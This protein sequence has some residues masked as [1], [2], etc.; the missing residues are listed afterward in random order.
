MASDD[1]ISEFGTAREMRSTSDEAAS[2]RLAA[3]TDAR[4][5]N[6]CNTG[7]EAVVT[8]EAVVI[9]TERVGTGDVVRLGRKAT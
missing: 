5:Q 3:S 8:T 2:R 4:S 6:V 1:G 7:A 9:G